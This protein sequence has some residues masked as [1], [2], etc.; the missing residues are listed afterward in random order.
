MGDNIATDVYFSKN[1]GIGSVLV[2]SGLAKMDKDAA[3]IAKAA[4][5]YII[6]KFA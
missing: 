4:P 1:A 6:E 3:E 5:S 2:L